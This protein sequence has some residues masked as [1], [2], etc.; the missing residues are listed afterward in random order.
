MGLDV[1]HD[2]WNGAYSAFTRWRT[3][4]AR[5]AG[6]PSLML[7][8]GFW[9]LRFTTL[10]YIAEG[11]SLGQST[12]VPKF[13]VTQIKDLVEN[14]PLKWESLKPDVIHILINHSDCD[15]SIAHKDCL[16]LAERLRELM[17]LLPS[18]D[19]AHGHIWSWKGVTQKFI[20]GLLLAHE[21][22]EDVEFG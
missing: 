22:G 11:E 5:A 3:E 1:S 9:P 14:L 10:Q 16:P 13:V 7:M 15:G 17:P 8:E 6:M 21:A 12:P 4:L 20:D 18:D 2:C 19:T